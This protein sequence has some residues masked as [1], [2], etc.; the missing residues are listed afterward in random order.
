MPV[1]FL[2]KKGSNK[3][4]MYEILATIGVVVWE[5]PEGVKFNLSP[6]TELLPHNIKTISL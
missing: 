4:N 5:A 2:K 3:M 1:F 6:W